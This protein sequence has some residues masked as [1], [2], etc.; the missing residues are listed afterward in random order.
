MPADFHKLQIAGII[1]ETHDT[2]SYVLA[3]PESLRE[4]FR[5]RA[6]QF[7]TFEVPWNGMQLHRCY[8][9]SSAPET[10]PWPKVTVK[11]VD[12]GRISNW[13]N[14]NVNVGDSIMVQPPE[15]RF[16]IRSGNLELSNAG[17]RIDRRSDW[18]GRLRIGNS[19]R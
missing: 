18:P 19:C 12:D 13:F 15:G 1:Q 16:T 6:G 5:Y 7:L 8:S 10:D 17:E 9:L 3:V 2:R 14:D 11:R 4:D